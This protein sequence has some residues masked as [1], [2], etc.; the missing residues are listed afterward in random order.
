LALGLRDLRL[1]GARCDLRGAERLLLVVDAVDA[2]RRG[3][4]DRASLARG[5]DAQER[6]LHLVGRLRPTALDD[7]LALELAVDGRH[8][9][10]RVGARSLRGDAAVAVLSL[11]ARIEE[12]LREAIAA[13]KRATTLVVVVELHLHALDVGR[14]VAVRIARPTADAFALD[15]LL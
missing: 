5:L 7:E 2:Q 8:V 3:I 13:L 15:R 9:D 14:A 12:G 11:L 10:P 4:E 1:A 6:A